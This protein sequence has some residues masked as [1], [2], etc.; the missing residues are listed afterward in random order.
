MGWRHRPVQQS[1]P[2]LNSNYFLFFLFPFS[3][4]LFFFPLRQNEM[5]KDGEAEMLQLLCGLTPLP[6]AKPSSIT[7]DAGP[8]CWNPRVS[9]H[10]PKGFHGG[11]A[12]RTRE[13][14]WPHAA[15]RRVCC[16]QV[17]SPCA[18]RY[19]CPNYGTAA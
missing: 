18:G 13:G 12:G 11:H 7:A 1:Q 4:I 5:R 2:K 19:C 15:L 3:F 16:H 8:S 10:S 9:A 14:P 6:L 17:S